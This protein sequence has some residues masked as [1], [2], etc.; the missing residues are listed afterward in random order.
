MTS[1]TSWRNTTE[2]HRQRRISQKCPSTTF[3]APLRTHQY[4]AAMPTVSRL[5]SRST[6]GLPWSGGIESRAARRRNQTG[7]T[8]L[9]T[10]PTAQRTASWGLPQWRAWNLAI[11]SGSAPSHPPW[12]RCVRSTARP[13]AS[14]ISPARFAAFGRAGTPRLNRS[15]APIAPARLGQRHAPRARVTP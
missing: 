15:G 1:V 5:R 8:R 9:S 11:S 4:Q 6:G 3:G 7:R 12:L 2:Q 13:S 14:N 10:S